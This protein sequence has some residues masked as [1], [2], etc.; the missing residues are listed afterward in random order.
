MVIS[1]FVPT[2]AFLGFIS[3]FN[4]F[5]PEDLFTSSRDSD[6][7]LL[8]QCDMVTS[9]GIAAAFLINMRVASLLTFS[10]ARMLD[11]AW[12]IVVAQGGRFLHGWFLY[13]FVLAPNLGR[14]MELSPVPIS[15]YL[16]LAFK[17][18]SMSSLLSLIKSFRG[19]KGPRATASAIFGIFAIGY[20]LAFAP[21]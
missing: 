19:F 12:D 13:R 17:E 20:V 2:F 6:K 3:S 7:Q 21:S 14:I 5:N 1:A 10:E 11:I 15:A 9:K 16:D 4:F 18:A 8:T